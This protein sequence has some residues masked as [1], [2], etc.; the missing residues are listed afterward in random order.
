VARRNAPVVVMGKGETKTP[1]LV[2]YEG[3]VFDAQTSVA[4]DVKLNE[5]D[6]YPA[7]GVKENALGAPFL[8]GSFAQEVPLTDGDYTVTTADAKFTLKVVVTKLY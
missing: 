4:V 7:G 2:V 8:L 6:N 5:V 1:N 3:P